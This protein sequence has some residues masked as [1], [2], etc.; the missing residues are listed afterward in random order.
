[1]LTL[2]QTVRR[3]RPFR[4]RRLMIARP[5]G[6]LMRLRKPCLF[7]RL[8]LLGWKVR[9]KEDGLEII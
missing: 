1:M 5:P 9:F 8:R 4:R 6:V 3:L 7:R 2:D